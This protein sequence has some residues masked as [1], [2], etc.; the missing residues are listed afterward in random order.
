M[1]AIELVNGKGVA[2]VDAG[3]YAAVVKHRWYN[4]RG[5]ARA[6]LARGWVYMHQMIAG[7][8]LGDLDHVNGDKLD[9]RRKN[10]RRCTHAQNMRGLRVRRKRGWS[11][12]RGVT[13]DKRRGV[14]LAQTKVNYRQYNI[15]RFKTELEAALAYDTFALE[16]FGEFA[17]PNI[18]HRAGSAV[19]VRLRCS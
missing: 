1:Q 10:L 17:S 11:R 9:N 4:V 5:Y 12:Y 2:L 14:W 18:L 7:P 19:T 16:H 13:W 3:D 6:K 8:G 15:G